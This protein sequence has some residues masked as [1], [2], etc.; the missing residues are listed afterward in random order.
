[1]NPGRGKLQHSTL[2]CALLTAARHP[3]HCGATR[4]SPK[5]NDAGALSAPITAGRDPTITAPIAEARRAKAATPIAAAAVLN[6]FEFAQQL[7]TA[8]PHDATPGVE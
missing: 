2:L 6:E 3:V 1:M 5:R 4:R 7:Q 8:S